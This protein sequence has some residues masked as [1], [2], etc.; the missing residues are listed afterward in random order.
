MGLPMPICCPIVEFPCKIPVL[1]YWSLSPHV[2]LQSS[3]R[4]YIVT[5]D[6]R[7][8]SWC[9]QNYARVATDGSINRCP[10]EIFNIISNNNDIENE[11][12]TALRMENSSA[13]TQVK[14]DDDTIDGDKDN[15]RCN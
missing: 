7:V 15:E 4:L 2:F 11:S 9:L 6:R 10:K 14:Q 13:E 12:T 8:F 3:F 5:N 1:Q